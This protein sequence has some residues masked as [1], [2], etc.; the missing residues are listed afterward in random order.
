MW[1]VFLN[2]MRP[3]VYYIALP[4]GIV[5]GGIG[6]YTIE[7]HRKETPYKEKTIQEERD[8]RKL[9]ELEERDA[10]DVAKLKSKIDIP[11]TVLDRQDIR[12]E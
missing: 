2:V 12:K 11:R 4:I 8:E 3:Y 10:T 5:V 1:Q 9:R 7:T 6:Y